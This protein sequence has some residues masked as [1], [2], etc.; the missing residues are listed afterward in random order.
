MENNICQ[1]CGTPM[2]EGQ[3]FCPNCGT[4]KAEQPVQPAQPEQVAQPVQ[5]VC[6]NC[7]T[8]LMPGQGFCPNC[9]AKADMA[10]DAGVS[11]AINQFNAGVVQTNE[12]NKKKPMKAIIA[13]IV[14][15]AIIVVGVV[16]LPKMFV[17]VEG[18]CEQGRYAEAYEKAEGS[19]K[20][21]VLAENMCAVLSEVTSTKLKNP[22]SF[23]LLRAYYY[24]FINSEG[25]LGGYV[26]LYSSGENSYGGTVSDYMA[27][28]WSPSD[29]Q[30]NYWGSCDT[31]E[32]ESGDEF[33]DTLVKIVVEA[34]IR[35]GIELTKTQV[36]HINDLF[37]ADKLWEVEFIDRDI[38]DTSRFSKD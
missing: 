15:L 10:V 14:A 6:P 22:S 1:N 16:A 27:Y 38:I 2:S 8:Q 36:K 32:E 26:I 3:M 4:R 5:N 12:A 18:L 29:Q 28:V 33:E 23:K 20:D 34:G 30:W 31:Y 35:K 13:A 11:S 21:E 25:E 24:P 9:G 19:E 7:G 17:S 37:E